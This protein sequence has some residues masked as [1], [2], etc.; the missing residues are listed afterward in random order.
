MLLALRAGCDAEV[1]AISAAM[2]AAAAR[3]AHRLMA[4]ARA[5]LALLWAPV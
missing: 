4:Q 1:E 2:N 3:A 5:P